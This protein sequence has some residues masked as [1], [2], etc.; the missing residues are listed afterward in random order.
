MQ[1]STA[2]FSVVAESKN[3][4]SRLSRPLANYDHGMQ[5]ISLQV[6]Q[7]CTTFCLPFT[8]WVACVGTQHSRYSN[9]VQNVLI[10]QGQGQKC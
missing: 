1:G 5:Q 10:M 8:A 3:N 7:R 9:T 6:P 2:A 4:F